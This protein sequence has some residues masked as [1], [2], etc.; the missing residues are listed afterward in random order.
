MDTQIRLG[1]VIPHGVGGPEAGAIDLI[2]YFLL[3]EY[4]QNSYNH[5]FINQIG[6]DLNEIILKQGKQININIRYP[7]QE[8]FELKSDYEKNRIR[9][10]VT[11]AALLRIAEK[12]KKLDIQILEIIKNKILENNF[13]FDFVLKTFKNKKPDNLFAK[14]IVQPKASSFL[15]YI[16]IEEDEKV[17]CKLP[18]Y[19]GFTNTFYVRKLF[20]IGK[21]KKNNDFIL[22]G[23]NGEVE[24]HIIVDSCEV[25]YINLTK[26]EKAP[27]FEIF[28]SDITLDESEKAR[29]DW[30]HSL[31]PAI[32]SFLR[33]ANN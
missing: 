9:L 33:D 13:S 28:R 25:K 22:K 27:S 21:W 23:K 18:I 1:S 26:Y 11:H 17:K 15:Y 6:E 30:H 8:D 16:Q 29:K 19:N 10:D 14:L 3:R 24:I 32:A 7:A 5:I 4:G 2:Y 20:G 12:E 31:P